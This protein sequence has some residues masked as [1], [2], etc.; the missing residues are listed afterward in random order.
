MKNKIYEVTYW[1]GT[2]PKNISK[3]FWHKL[4]LKITNEALNALCEGA[5][6]ISTMGLDNKEII[7]MSSNITRI[8]EIQQL[9]GNAG[10]LL[11][12][13]TFFGAVDKEH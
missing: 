3:G 7:L 4:K 12:F 9:F 8:K 11:L 6:F 2:S 1:D 10:Q 5:P 13:W